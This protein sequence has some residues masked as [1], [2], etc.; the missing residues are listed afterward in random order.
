MVSNKAVKL[1]QAQMIK[2]GFALDAHGVYGPQSKS[3]CLA[4]QRDQGLLA[5]GIVG[6]ATW[7]AAFAAL[8]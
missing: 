8:I 7:T 5:D 6:R 3:A 1:W 4:F 2:R